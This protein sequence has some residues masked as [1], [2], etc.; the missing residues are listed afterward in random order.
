MHFFSLVGLLPRLNS[1]R[2]TLKLRLL[3]MI[4]V[5]LLSMGPRSPLSILLLT[6]TGLGFLRLVERDTTTTSPFACAL[7]WCLL[8]YH[9]FFT[10]GHTAEFASL[11][12]SCGF[13]GMT[14]FDPVI[15]PF[16]VCRFSFSLMFSMFVQTTKHY[17]RY[18]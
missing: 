17:V 1:N 14:G 15:S 5:V 10:T 11:Q 4:P 8:G 6:C 16:W 18:L 2:D 12:H 9:G 7:F 13:V 3:C